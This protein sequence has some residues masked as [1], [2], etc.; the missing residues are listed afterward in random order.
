MKDI[1]FCSMGNGVSV[2]HKDGH[3]VGHINRERFVKIYDRNYHYDVLEFATQYNMKT[4]ASHNTNALSDHDLIYEAK[5]WLR[6]WL[7]GFN[8]EKGIYAT[9][10]QMVADSAWRVYRFGE[11]NETVLGRIA[12]DCRDQVVKFIE[13]KI[14]EI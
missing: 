14:D 1:D 10:P 6:R 3:I 2:Y 4:D 8:I 13:H 5:S 9:L 11:D 7:P 12:V